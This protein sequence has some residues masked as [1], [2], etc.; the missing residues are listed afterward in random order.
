[1]GK[2]L[3][4]EFSKLIKAKVFYIC[5]AISV[6]III[7]ATIAYPNN[8]V[9]KTGYI[10]SYGSVSD[11]VLMLGIC[12]PVFVCQDAFCGAEKTILG[13]GVSR[14]KFFFAKYISSLV[15]TVIFTFVVIG[16]TAIA[17]VI[18]F[19]SAP[20]S[21][22]VQ[23]MFLSLLGIFMLHAVF[24]GISTMSNKLIIALII[25]ILL[26][27]TLSLIANLLEIYASVDG[28]TFIVFSP[29][30]MFTTL[31]SYTEMN[32]VMGWTIG[33][34]SALLIIML[35]AAHEVYIRKEN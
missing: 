12:I 1:M 28:F 13:R 21:S 17:G 19:E 5:L 20:D 34:A 4:F 22:F 10:R 3:K 24:F 11:L 2:L 16:V 7:F 23:A 27:S 15:A 33:A 30:D 31:A 26:P 35:V 18:K 29:S 32:S 9:S 14:N 6:L 8:L 25:T